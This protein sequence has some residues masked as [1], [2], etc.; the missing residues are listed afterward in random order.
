MW[1]E[2]ESAPLGK[3]VLLWAPIWRH[4]FPGQRNGDDGAVYVDTC[5][6]EAK[7]WQTFATHWVEFP[8]KPI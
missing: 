3:M 2:I 1:K 5:E 7:G 6:P 4:P 8:D